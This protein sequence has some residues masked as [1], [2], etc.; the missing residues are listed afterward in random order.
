MTS[1]LLLFLTS[2]TCKSVVIASLGSRSEMHYYI[3]SADFYK[4]CNTCSVRPNV[5]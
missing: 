3:M 4:R 2:L 5:A 1:Q